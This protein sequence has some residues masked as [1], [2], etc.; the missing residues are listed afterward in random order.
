MVNGVYSECSAETAGFFLFNHLNK[1]AALGK[2]AKR[3]SNTTI[4]MKRV[5][6]PII[7]ALACVLCDI[8]ATAQTNSPQIL[9]LTSSQRPGTMFV[10]ITYDLVDPDNQGAYIL[11]EASSNGGSTY[12]VPI[13][14]LSGDV[15]FVTPGNGKKIVWNAWTDWANNYTTN[16]KIRLTADA[17]FKGVALN[18]TTNLSPGTNF[19]WIPSGTFS[20]AFDYNA[21]VYISRGF[22]MGKFEVTQG[23]YIAV[24]TNNPSFHIGS[25]NYPV[26]NVTWYEAVQYCQLRT[27]KERTAGIISTNWGYRLPTEA[28]W[29]YASRAQTGSY[30]Y[31]GDYPTVT[32]RL[33]FYAW[34]SL[35]SGNTTHE[36][37]GRIPNRWGLF[38]VYG[39]VWE[40][41]SDWAG[42]RPSGNVT[43]PQGASSS[44]SKMLR[45]DSYANG[46]SVH[47]A[48][49]SSDQPSVRRPIYGFR[50]VLAPTP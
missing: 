35:N 47:Y 19:A 20:T 6:L 9:N 10:D 29:E 1:T 22:W 4:T 3:Q 48:S 34:Y 31:F 12:A 42:N 18:T 36:V 14:A 5:L 7:S 30:Y 16:A 32:P 45:G 23:E 43:D 38:D 44:S 24:M 50:I 21:N 46:G 17:S 41:C 8:E 33:P 11:V 39:N 49:A 40:W 2:I 26:E 25:T 27:I 15:Q 37:G 28:E 13:Y